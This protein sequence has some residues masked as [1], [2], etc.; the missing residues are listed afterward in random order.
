MRCEPTGHEFER[1]I[2][3][4][5]S[6]FIEKNALFSAARP[7]SSLGT[8]R[9]TFSGFR[10]QYW[11]NIEVVLTSEVPALLG[12]WIGPRQRLLGRAAPG[13]VLR[14]LQPTVPYALSPHSQDGS[15]ETSA[16]SRS[17]SNS[18]DSDHTSRRSPSWS[19]ADDVIPSQPRPRQGWRIIGQT[20]PIVRRG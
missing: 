11:S 13:D 9:L 1:S 20:V 8:V 17:V 10:N 2:T 14:L 15:T 19:R 5:I 3:S 12:S 7:L 4:A 6:C 18:P 16:S